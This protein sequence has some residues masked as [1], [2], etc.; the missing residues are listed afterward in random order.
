MSARRDPVVARL[1]KLADSGGTGVLR[2]AG[3]LGGAI[4]LNQGDVVFAESQGTP[5]L[6]R[7]FPAVD[8]SQATT[9]S[10]F[11]RTLAVREAIIDAALEL[12]P[13]RPRYSRFR[14]T[15]PP[16][17]GD[18]DGM[19]VA[20]LLAEVTR[21]QAIVEQLSTLLT[22]DTAIVRNPHIST[23]AVHV[24]APQ[25]AVLIRVGDQSTPRTLAFDLGRSVFSTTIEVFRLLVLRL[26]S[27]S[28]AP[29]QP[30]S[31]VADGA[32]DRMRLAVSFIR[33]VTG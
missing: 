24:S 25:W 6:A 2:V 29:V 3:D 14:A 5:G 18:R 9:F 4:Y 13:G 26:L 19:T 10:S 30:A 15:G 11:E 7:R 22:A 27:V 28:D 31:Q 8:A 16:G 21:R 17:A 23:R 1:G 12:L 20:A 32:P 33:A